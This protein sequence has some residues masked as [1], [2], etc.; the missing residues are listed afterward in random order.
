MAMIKQA[1][2]PL[3]ALS[4]ASQSGPELSRAREWSSDHPVNLRLSIPFIGGRY[5][6]TVVAGR[7]RRSAARRAAERKKHPLAT[8]GNLTFM[9]LV[10]TLLGVASMII[11]YQGSIHI[12]Q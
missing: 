1:G 3:S 8:L 6:L 2:E 9:A 7:E 4:E 10:G 5:Y 12:F 11:L